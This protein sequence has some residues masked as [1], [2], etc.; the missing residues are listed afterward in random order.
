M[1]LFIRLALAMA[2]QAL[3]TNEERTGLPLSF[4]P[5]PSAAFMHAESRVKHTR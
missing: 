1:Y 4:C 5:S 3:I 2:P